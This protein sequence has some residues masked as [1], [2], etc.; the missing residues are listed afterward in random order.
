MP[1]VSL[2]H[3]VSCL[4]SNYQTQHI[5]PIPNTWFAF[6]TLPRLS[7]RGCLR[8]VRSLGERGRGWT[9]GATREARAGLGLQAADTAAGSLFWDQT[10]PRGIGH[11][12]EIAVF[13]LDSG[14]QAKFAQ[15]GSSNVT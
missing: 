12:V 7:R 6:S 11:P 3:T 2:P 4:I 1:F 14:N 5:P 8:P 15:A 13:F 9:W 10:R